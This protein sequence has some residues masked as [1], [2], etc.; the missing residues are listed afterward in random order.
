MNFLMLDPET[1]LVEER[2]APLM[3]LLERH[4]ITPVPIRLR[5]ARTLG[6]GAHCVTL[7]TRRRGRLES[8]CD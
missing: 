6:G 8:Y 1:A 3:R 5:H 7:D 2:Q 4:R